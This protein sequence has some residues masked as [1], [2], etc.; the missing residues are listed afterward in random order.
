LKRNKLKNNNLEKVLSFNLC[1]NVF[2]K[3]VFGIKISIEILMGC[4]GSTHATTRL[5]I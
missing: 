2:E 4:R 5:S 3:Y 1:K